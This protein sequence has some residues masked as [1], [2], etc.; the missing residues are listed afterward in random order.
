MTFHSSVRTDRIHR[1]SK[2][3]IQSTT[4]CQSLLPITI[5]YWN[6]SR[7]LDLRSRF[8]ELSQ[9]PVED[10]NLLQCFKSKY[11]PYVQCVNFTYYSTILNA[12][13]QNSQA[14]LPLF[15]SKK[16]LRGVRLPPCCG[17]RQGGGLLSDNTILSPL[18]RAQ[19][20]EVVEVVMYSNCKAMM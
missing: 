19:R 16:Y 3:C 11:L 20:L 17:W 6:V 2:T 9:T 8:T 15:I 18:S 1:K 5:Y 13:I 10:K 14:R 4:V 7:N 12:H